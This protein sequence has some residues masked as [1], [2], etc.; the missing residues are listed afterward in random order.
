MKRRKFIRGALGA[1]GA[2]AL[3]RPAAALTPQEIQLGIINSEITSDD[4]EE[5]LQFI[6]SYGLNWAEMKILWGKYN[7]SQ[8]IESV[9]RA[10]DLLDKYELRVPL[11]AT[12]FFK[13]ELPPPG[14]ARDEMM[15]KQHAILRKAIENAKI[16][17]TDRIRAFAFTVKDP[18][19][20]QWDDAMKLLEEATH[21]AENEGIYLAVENIFNNHVETG[22]DVERMLHDVPNPH[23][24][25]IWEPNNAAMAGDWSPLN[26]L[27][28]VDVNRIYDVHLRD[29]RRTNDGGF[30]WCAVG[31]GELDVKGTIQHLL[32]AGYEGPFTLETHYTP[33]GGTKKDGSRMSIE[34]LLKIVRNL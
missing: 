7:T 11:L 24:G 20:R 22:A 8:D 28:R 21:I 19:N 14:S 15:K 1:A 2:L 16:F 23:L 34:A 32:S 5:A 4:V 30:K 29:G 12:G 18:S 27:L 3:V 25:V 26:G 33:P 6:K 31:D 13:V 17:E 10:K 9:K